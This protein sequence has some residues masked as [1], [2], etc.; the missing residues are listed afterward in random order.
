MPLKTSSVL[1]QLRRNN[2]EVKFSLSPP[3]PLFSTE[4]GGKLSPRR[5]RELAKYAGGIALN[6]HKGLGYCGSGCV[7]DHGDVH[8]GGD[9]R[10]SDRDQCCYQPLPAGTCTFHN[11]SVPALVESQF[12]A[13]S[14]QIATE[15]EYPFLVD[16]S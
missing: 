15:A 5:S 13:P 14:E 2:P 4:T 12:L 10:G 6:L 16:R 9:G 1:D 7:R 11:S 8:E 3:H